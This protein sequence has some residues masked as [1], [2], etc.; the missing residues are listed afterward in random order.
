[1]SS[2]ET[3]DHRPAG[4]SPALPQR[5]VRLLIVI[6]G[7]ERTGRIMDL[8]LGLARKGLVIEAIL[9]GV[10]RDPPDGRLRGYGSFKRKEVHARLHD[11]MGTRAVS[12]AARRL[13][14][15]GIVHQERLE[16]GNPVRTILRVAGEEACDL[17]LVADARAGAF[18]RRLPEAVGLT[19]AT[20]A[21]RVALLAPVPVVVVK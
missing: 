2:L 6:D 12:A 11:L 1:M 21:S 8:A 19:V 5:P 10:I 18:R 4:H 7:S 16:V 14:R 15:A 9:L 13:D 20:V 17:I 3:P